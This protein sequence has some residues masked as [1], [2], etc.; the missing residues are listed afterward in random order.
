MGVMGVCSNICTN[1]SRHP[2]EDQDDGGKEFTST[3]RRH[4]GLTFSPGSGDIARSGDGEVRVRT[5]IHWVLRASIIVV[6]IGGMYILAKLGG[7]GHS[8]ECVNADCRVQAASS[9]N[10]ILVG[11]VIAVLALLLPRPSAGDIEPVGR[12]AGYIRRL[13]AFLIDYSLIMIAVMPLSAFIPLAL[14][15][16]YTG[17]FVWSFERDYTRASD[18][19]TALP[20]VVVFVG[21]YFYFTRTALAGRQTI[22][23]FAMGFRAQIAGRIWSGLTG[24]FF[25]PVVLMGVMPRFMFT[26]TGAMNRFMGFER[27][28]V[29]LDF[30]DKVEFKIVR[31]KPPHQ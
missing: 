30:V 6:V 28:A 31:C 19:L 8:L 25:A 20:I 13:L 5:I 18:W 15:S 21:L 2:D 26:I 16:L 9:I 29:A 22:G 4:P 1:Q 11:S 3:V 12:T 10:A 17:E 14:E 23:Q 27:Q 24:T 7:G